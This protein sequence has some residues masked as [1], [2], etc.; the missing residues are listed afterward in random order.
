MGRMKMGRMKMGRMKMGRMGK[1]VSKKGD[2]RPAE[3]N[4]IFLKAVRLHGRPP[5]RPLGKFLG[6]EKTRFF[7]GTVFFVSCGI[8]SGFRSG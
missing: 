4:P 1:M 3:N 8:T 6:F 2:T 5:A 7:F